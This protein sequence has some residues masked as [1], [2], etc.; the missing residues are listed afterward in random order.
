[1]SKALYTW[2][3]VEVTPYH[4]FKLPARYTDV[5]L[6]Y[7][8]FTHGHLSSTTLGTTLFDLLNFL[9]A[10]RLL[11]S[12]HCQHHHAQQ[13]LSQHRSSYLANLLLLY[14]LITVFTWLIITETNAAAL[15]NKQLLTLCSAKWAF[16]NWYRRLQCNDV[17]VWYIQFVPRRASSP[18]D[19]VSASLSWAGE[20]SPTLVA[21]PERSSKFGKRA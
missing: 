14:D 17:T 7:V 16:D 8:L 1:M 9:H 21:A 12:Q 13:S 11:A 15:T 18:F 20:Q 6:L 5:V 4:G 2:K 3:R 10:A 19:S